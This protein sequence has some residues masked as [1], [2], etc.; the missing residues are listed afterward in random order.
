MIGIGCVDVDFATKD[1]G[2]FGRVCGGTFESVAVAI[3]SFSLTVIFVVLSG[4]LWNVIFSHFF[5]FV[6]NSLVIRVVGQ[7]FAL[8]QAQR[9]VQR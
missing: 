6:F 1:G 3:V 4:W 2:V 9:P 7:T 5:V 8:I